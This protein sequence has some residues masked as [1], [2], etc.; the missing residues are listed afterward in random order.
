MNNI[1]CSADL[2]EAQECQ[3]QEP[4]GNPDTP[5]TIFAVKQ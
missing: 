1:S 3:A 4:V 5:F 2:P